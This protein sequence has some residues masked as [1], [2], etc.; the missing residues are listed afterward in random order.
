VIA[1]RE[2]TVGKTEGNSAMNER[3]AVPAAVLSSAFGGM[4]AAVTRYAIGVA[5]PLTLAAFRFGIGFA[6]L[7]PVVLALRSRF[8]SRRDWPGVAALGLLFFAVFFV[9]YNLSLGRTTAAR[10]AL[11]LSV[12]PLLTMIIAA[13]LGIESLTARKTS[14]V[15]VAMAGV[16]SAL[17]AGLGDAPAGAWR[18][19]L[20]M[21][22]GAICMALYNVWSRPFIAR[23][24]PLGF[25]T[26]GMGIGAATLIVIA[27]AS[28]GF[29]VVARFGAPQF[30][31]MVFLGVFGAALNFYLWV[32]ALERTTPTRVANT[33]TVNPITASL[34]AAFLVGEKIGLDLVL[35][36]AAV[37]TGIWIA[38]TE[39]AAAAAK[40]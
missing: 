33:I 18:G 10:G 23:S 4:A 39:R 31:A 9:L 1:R 21:V 15:L 12:L 17:A 24:S 19:D 35:G 13:L 38:S 40:R 3:L 22:A 7:L 20:I 34:L 6:V 2:S 26:A 16:A 25:L 37:F 29:A 32:F 36:I 8:P 11:A 27:G 30:V 5:D 14:G 28:G